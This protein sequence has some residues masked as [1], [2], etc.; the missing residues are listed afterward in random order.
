MSVVRAF[1]SV[2]IAALSLVLLAWIGRALFG[3]DQRGPLLPFLAPFSFDAVVDA[4]AVPLLAGVDWAGLLTFG[5]S[6]WDSTSKTIKG[7]V[8]MATVIESSTTG[9]SVNDVPQYQL[10]LEVRPTDGHRYVSQCRLLAS[11][12][13]AWMVE[14]GVAVPVHYDLNQPDYVTPAE[15]A[16]PEVRRAVLQWRIERGLIEPRLI[17]A[18]LDGRSEHASVIDLRPTGRHQDGQSE[19]EIRLLVSPDGQDPFE[20]TSRVFVYPESVAEVQ[21]GSPV[22][23]YW[24]PGDR[25]NVAIGV[26]RG[27]G[28]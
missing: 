6:T 19:L 20:T 11:S 4:M 14:P 22:R 18:Y 24:L 5:G 1:R 3:T 7:P 17:R 25:E 28:R 15:P 12:R 2:L 23:A 8:A 16:E 13:D 10:Y 21:V 9:L 27:I 26:G